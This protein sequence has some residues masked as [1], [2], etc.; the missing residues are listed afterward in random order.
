LLSIDES[1][2]VR[3]PK[4]QITLANLQP[5][6]RLAQQLLTADGR[7]LLSE[8]HVLSQLNINRLLDLRSVMTDEFL[9]VVDEGPEPATD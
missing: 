3:A 9:W 6:L 2:W 4:R 1:K 5:G 7:L 8:G